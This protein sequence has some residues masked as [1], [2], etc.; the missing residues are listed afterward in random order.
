MS[1]G[2]RGYYEGTD[3]KN[4]LRIARNCDPA[5]DGTSLAAHRPR[6]F[7]TDDEPDSVPIEEFDRRIE[8]RVPAHVL[9]RMDSV[10]RSAE[11][12]AQRGLADTPPLDRYEWRRGMI[13]SWSHARDLATVLDAL[14]HPRP[15][16]DRHDLDEVVLGKHL[17][18][19]LGSAD[20]WYIDYVSSLDDG[21]WVN[22]GFF[23]PHLSA[24]MFKWGDARHGKQNAM[25]AHRLSSHHLGNP[26]AP[27]EWIER[28]ANFVVH[29]IP[30]EHYGIRH[31][32]RG[33]FSQ[34]E[35]VLA[36]DTAI[37]DSEIGKAIARDVARL[38]ELLEQEGKIIPWNLLKVPADTLNVSLVEHA[39]L[40]AST[41]DLPPADPIDADEYQRQL[42]RA[43][44]VIAR[45]PLEAE[46]AEAGGRGEIATV[47]RKLLREGGY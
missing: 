9:A 31:E 28:A 10:M 6:I 40:V 46:K 32:P 7:D 39:F 25:D 12:L 17:K 42:E 38:C 30:R 45:V 2:L 16:V 44:A 34:L 33:E 41:A 14:G 24:S 1:P 15:T 4:V 27:L 22:V 43:K 18:G 26:E 8:A 11:L 23:N 13:L 20:Q 35:H 21:A 5:I 3:G 37:K 19:R 36:T 47:F 29:H